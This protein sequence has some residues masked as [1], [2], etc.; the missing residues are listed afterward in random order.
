M[1]KHKA[2]LIS[3][4]DQLAEAVR[5]VFVERGYNVKISMVFDFETGLAFNMDEYRIPGKLLTQEIVN[6][7]VAEGAKRS[8]YDYFYHAYCLGEFGDTQI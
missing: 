3:A 6:E 5:E 1:D 7:I 4:T 2:Q 8:G